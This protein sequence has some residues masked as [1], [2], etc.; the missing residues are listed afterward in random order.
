MRARRVAATLFGV[1]GLL[2][3]S[4]AQASA[5]PVPT[6]CSSTTGYVVCLLGT[7][8]SGSPAI[9]VLSSVDELANDAVTGLLGP[10]FHP[11]PT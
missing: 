1:A 3:I 2:G 11:L 6:S 4:A 9:D 10:G 5:G 7:T 8:L